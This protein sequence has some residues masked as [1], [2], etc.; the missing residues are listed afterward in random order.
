VI[1]TRIPPPRCT[2]DEADTITNCLSSTRFTTTIVPLLIGS[3]NN[4]TLRHDT[5][6]AKTSSSSGNLIPDYGAHVPEDKDQRLIVT[7]YGEGVVVRTFR[8]H[9]SGK[10]TMQEIAL[11]SWGT[12]VSTS[13]ATS[14]RPIRPAT[15]HSPIIYPSVLVTVG[16]DVICTY[17]RGRVTELRTTTAPLPPIVVVRISSWRL[18]HRSRVTCF[19]NVNSVQVVRPNQVYEMSVVEKIEHALELKQLAATQFTQKDYVGAL[20][21]Y[22]KAIDSVKFVQHTP[23]STNSVRADL[24]VVMITCSNN[25]ATCCSKLE[26]LD[27]A[28]KHAQQALSL[29]EALEAKKGLKIHAELQREGHSDVRVFGEWKVK[30]LMIIAHVLVEKDEVVEALDVIKKAREV[31]AAYTTKPANA[32]SS[33]LPPQPTSKPLLGNDKDLVKLLARCKERRKAQLKREKQRAQA[34]FASTT[35]AP[36]SRN[37]SEQAA[38]TSTLHS[39]PNGSHQQPESS[40]ANAPPLSVA[41]TTSANSDDPPLPRATKKSPRS[42]T[43]AH[44]LVDAIKPEKTIHHEEEKDD[45]EDVA[46]H[47]D[48]YFLGGLGFLVG[49]FGTI[50]LASQKWRRNS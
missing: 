16:C 3:S 11:T 6:M 46:W 18:A 43:F 47:Q 4:Y 34:M 20:Q 13:S 28:K 33:P 26:Q 10:V 35:T 45:E 29:V 27:E 42:V 21:T 30:S 48:P 36:S 49:V 31:I 9:A 24:L 40:S 25:A 38:T 41:T 5:D 39:T 2:Q 15:L 12:A 19:M 23:N 37:S 32:D 17:G 50:L 44:D 14:G 8:N 7:P 22:A 1:V